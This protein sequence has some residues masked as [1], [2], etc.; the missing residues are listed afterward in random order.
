MACMWGCRLAVP[1][2]G[3][4]WD[5]TMDEVRALVD[6]VHERMGVCSPLDEHF[7]NLLGTGKLSSR[8][9]RYLVHL[10]GVR[11]VVLGAYKIR[12]PHVDALAYLAANGP[13]A[14]KRLAVATTELDGRAINAAVDVLPDDIRGGPWYWRGGATTC[15]AAR[16]QEHCAWA[17][18]GAARRSLNDDLRE[19]ECAS[20]RLQEKHGGADPLEWR[21]GEGHACASVFEADDAKR[22]HVDLLMEV[23]VLRE[24]M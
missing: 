23:R 18:L 13:A 5:A 3:T 8:V 4:G 15:P 1:L 22:E 17:H 11:L 7:L 24:A 12:S 14:T 19:A 6:A 9:P 20:L 10:R 21:W 16:L 2:S